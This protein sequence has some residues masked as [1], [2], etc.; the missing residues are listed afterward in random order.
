MDRGRYDRIR[1]SYAAW[2]FGRSYRA[3]GMIVSLSLV[4]CRAAVGFL[5]DPD[6]WLELVIHAL[7]EEQPLYVAKAEVRWLEGHEVGLEFVQMD[8]QDVQRLS[9]L[10][11]TIEDAP[12]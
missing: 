2:F 10:I 1:V 4:G 5:I 6:E 3:P 12:E 11:R 8:W 9:D 7:I